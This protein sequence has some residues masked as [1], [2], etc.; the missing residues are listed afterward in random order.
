MRR[1]MAMGVLSLSLLF[2]CF[3]QALA[4]KIVLENGD[5]LTGTVEK[6]VGGKLTLKTDYAGAIEIQVEK[7]KQIF[8]DH[9]AEVH[10]SSGEVLKGKIRTED[11]QVVV[12][13]SPEREAAKVDWGKVASVNPPP[14][15][16]WSGSINLGGNLQS[17][18]TDRKAAYV[19]A[20]ATRKTEKDRFRVSYEFTYGQQDGETT[21]QSNYGTAEYD[22]FFTKQFYGYGAAEFLNDKFQ[23]LNLRTTVGGGVG[24]QVWDDP[25]KALSGEAGLSYVNNNYKSAPD[26]SYLAARLGGFFRYK[27]FDF[28]VFSERI[29]YY[30]SLQD[31]GVYT[32]RNEAR[33]TAPLGARWALDFANIFQRNSDPP[34]GVKAND[35]QWILS[36]QYSF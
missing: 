31:S 18:N 27:L 2:L 16:D 32:L 35:V 28:I 13:Q 33:L 8:T 10:L 22:Y 19:A 3:G 20:S 36:L 1:L 14:P 21:A 5:T 11:Q 15:K 25:I 12:E 4:D 17:G 7:I 23:D 26:T 6:V 29:L 9:P 24:Y 34:P 30:P